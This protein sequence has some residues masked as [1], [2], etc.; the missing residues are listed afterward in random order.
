[1]RVEGVLTLVDGQRLFLQDDTGAAMA[2]FKQEV[3]LDSQFGSSR[4]SFWRTPSIP[5]PGGKP[6][7]F[8]PGD[9]VE[10]VGFQDAHGY[11]PVL[12]E[13]LARKTGGPGK[14]DLQQIAT[15]SFSD[16]RLDSY[17]VKLTGVLLG[18]QLLGEQR[19]LE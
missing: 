11:S 10:V 6:L 17:L 4:W 8:S 19:V 9:R 3:L 12:T 16:W 15:N 13:A 18:Q 5:G 14:V 7:P 1:V 2:I